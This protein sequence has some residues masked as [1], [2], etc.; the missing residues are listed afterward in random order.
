MLKVLSLLSILAPL[1]WCYCV[2]VTYDT[3]GRAHPRWLGNINVKPRYELCF[4][5]GKASQLHV[6][7][8]LPS[9]LEKKLETNYNTAGISDYNFQNKGLYGV[10]YERY[11]SPGFVPYAILGVGLEYS[12]S[13]FNV[14]FNTNQE[15]NL[16]NFRANRLALSANLMTLVTQYGLIGYATG[17]LGHVSYRKDYTGSNPTFSFTEGLKNGGP[18]YRIGYGFEY[19]PFESLGFTIE[20]G[21]GRGAYGRIGAVLWF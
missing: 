4:G 14:S 21:Y 10:R 1:S 7:T 12:F 5:D 19:F 17:Q 15:S 13:S 8:G 20:G 11:I 16:L 3:V 2:K 18:D 6:Y 9:D